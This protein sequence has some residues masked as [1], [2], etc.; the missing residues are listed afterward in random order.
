[1]PRRLDARYSNFNSPFAQGDYRSI[2]LSRSIKESFQFQA[3]AGLQKFISPV[4]KDNG[5]RFLNASGEFFLG[6]HY[7][8]DTGFTITRGALQNYNQMYTTF[9]Y[10]FDNRWKRE[11]ASATQK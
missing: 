3:Q 2:S 1:M 6:R 10:R 9:G 5:S 4:S 7:F 11:A 8:I